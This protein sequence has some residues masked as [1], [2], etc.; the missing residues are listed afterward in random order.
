MYGCVGVCVYGEGGGGGVSTLYN[1]LKGE[2]L[3]ERGTFFRPQEYVRVG[4]SPVKV[5][6]RVK[7]SVSSVCKKAK[8]G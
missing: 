6:E 3:S 1:C 8:K 2:A 4:I 5:Y 7:K